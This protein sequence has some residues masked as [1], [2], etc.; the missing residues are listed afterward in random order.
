MEGC[1]RVET[2]TS[3]LVADHIKAHKGNEALFWSEVNLQCMCKPCHDSAKQAIEKGSN[4]PTIGL[5][6]WPLPMGGVVRT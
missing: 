3:Q 4:K 1:G 2:D 5:D 6:G